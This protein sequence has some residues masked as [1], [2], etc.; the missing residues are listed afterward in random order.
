[1]TY[2]DLPLYPDQS[3]GTNVGLETGGDRPQR[4]IAEVGQPLVS[5]IVAERP[6]GAAVVICPGGG[7]RRVCVDK[8]GLDFAR[9]LA[10]WGITTL[11][12]TYR[13][14]GGVF[15]DPPVPVQDARRALA[16][17][18]DRADEWHLDPEKLVLMGFS[19]GGHLALTTVREPGPTGLL[20]RYLVL[21]Y[22]VVSLQPPLVHEGSRDNLLGPGA[23]AAL[24]ERFCAERDW[25]STGNGKPFTGPVFLVHAD[26]DQSVPVGNS[27]VLASALGEAGLPVVLIRHPTGGHGFG[28]GPASGYPAAPDWLPRLHRWLADQ[29]LA[30]N[31]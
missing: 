14:P 13:Q 22:P 28:L 16:L 15:S 3:A 17:A 7:Y 30:W 26:D 1:M 18:M 11:V 12:L 8:E 21:G 25:L 9:R 4:L 29:G 10:G 31:P 6:T 27:L 23:P 2:Y 24:V 20:P 5:V 19:A